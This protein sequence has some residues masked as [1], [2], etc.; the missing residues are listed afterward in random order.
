MFSVDNFYDYLSSEYCLPRKNNTLWAFQTHGDRSVNKLILWDQSNWPISTEVADVH[1]QSHYFGKM[2]MFDQE[3]ILF[4]QLEY[5]IDANLTKS[6]WLDYYTIPEQLVRIGAAVHQSFICHSEKNSDEVEYFKDRGFLDVH[7]WY[8]GL[9]ARDWFRHWK[10]FT[11]LH[12]EHSQ[13]FGCY[14]RDTSGTRKYREQLL[15]FIKAT[16]DIYCPLLNGN[17]YDSDASAMLEWSDTGA[18]DI[19]LVAETLFDTQKTHLTE[20][21]LKPVAMEQPFILFAGPNS[22]EYMRDYGFQTFACCWDESYDEIEDS[23]ERYAAITNLISNLNSL[24]RSQYNRIL[25]RAK[26]IAKNNREHFYSQE[27]EDLLLNELHTNLNTAYQTQAES[28]LNNPGGL[29][30][31]EAEKFMSIDDPLIHNIRP[32]N[33]ALLNLIKTQHPDVAKQIL[34]QYPDLF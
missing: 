3:P 28:F 33:I 21:V 20:K 14:I 11:P 34:K 10:H 7:Y 30:F 22:L 6:R 16:N 15:E 12:A 13:R 19:H 1:T 24:T 8:H 31:K 9:I 26:L 4:D 23:Q 25:K 27:F 17:I 18:F 29:Y 5:T 32:R 2:M